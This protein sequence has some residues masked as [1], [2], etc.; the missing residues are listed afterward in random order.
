MATVLN[1]RRHRPVET[2]DESTPSEPPK[3]RRRRWVFLAILLMLLGVVFLPK[4]V[5]HTPALNW[6]VGSAAS[7]LRGSLSVESASLGWFSPV[8]LRDVR[9]EDSEGRPVLEVPKLSG[10]KSLLAILLNSSLLGEF[11]LDKPKLSISLRD[12]GSNVED[13]LADYLATDEESQRVGLRLK[14]IDGSV[15][16]V[17]TAAER[18]WRIDNL[19]LTLAT[20]SDPTR[21]VELEASAAIADPTSPGRL[22]VKLT[23]GAASAAKPS[24]DEK[25]DPPDSTGELAIETEQF[26]LDML[27][28][29]IARFSPETHLSGRV[30]SQ[31]HARWG[32]NATLA[33]DLMAENLLLATPALGSDRVD[34][35]HLDATCQLARQEGR[36]QIDEAT[37]RCDL[38]E[39]VVAAVLHDDETPDRGS[40]DWLS[41]QTYQVKGHLELVPLARMLPGTLRLRDGMQVTSGRLQLALASQPGP[42]GMLWEGTLESTDVTAVHRGQPIAW[43]NPIHLELAAHETPD[44]P[45]LDDLTCRSDFLQLQAGQTGGDLAASAQ[46][47]LKQL[48]DQLGRFADLGE[49]DFRGDGWGLLTWKRDAEQ[50][51]LDL[52]LQVHNFHLGLPEQEPWTEQSLLLLLAA[53]GQ[54]RPDE[55][56]RLLSA[57]LAV[58]AGGDRLEVELIAPVDRISTDG[59]WPVDLRLEGQLDR[60]PT[61]IRPWVADSMDDWPEPLRGWIEKKDYHASGNYKLQARGTGSTKQIVVEAAQLTIDRLHLSG[62]SLNV[63]QPRVVLDVAGQWDIEPGR[64]RLKPAGFSSNIVSLQ[65]DEL[66]LLLGG[67]GPMQMAGDVRFQGDLAPICQLLATPDKPLAWRMTGRLDGRAE[68]SQTGKTTQGRLDANI[69]N[70]T[71]VDS[72]NHRLVEPTVHLVAQGSYQ[73]ETNTVKLD[74]LQLASSSL[75][76][77]I[78]GQLNMAGETSTLN[79]AG[80]LNYDLERLAVLLRPYLGPDIRITGQGKRNISFDGPLDPAQA[81]AAA[82]LAWQSADVYGFPIGPGDLKATLANG[83]LRTEPI[84]LAISQGHVRLEPEV[85]FTDAGAQLVLPSGALVTQIQITPRMCGHALQYIAPVLAGVTEASGAFSVEL[86]GCRI[87]LADATQ[88]EL[89]GRLTVHSVQIGPGP[90]LRQFAMLL[91]RSGPARLR[92]ESVVRFH[93]IDGRVHHS[94]LELVFPDV[95]I[96]TAGSV[97]VDQT[98]SMIAEMP[99]PSKWIGDNPLGVAMRNQ[100]IRL[101]ITGTLSQPKIDRRQFDQIARQLLEGAARNVIQD[102][103]NRQLQHLFGPPP[104]VE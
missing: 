60:W 95:T 88:G 35:Q 24:N 81:R 28:P 20:S 77:G 47:D 10:K 57:S 76:A 49:L 15:S 80:E 19:Q 74:E 6:I 72:T 30:S 40:A 1:L 41:R 96:R 8:V 87:P 34:L 16:I 100:T 68:L 42:Q 61:R 23:L 103:L 99:I 3:K 86:D 104:G 84:D 90:L 62:P 70:L 98:L 29:L 36:I 26:P 69:T 78:Q 11:Q 39:L 63:E 51:Q 67:D 18:T 85:H 43:K 45:V 54:N 21:P 89:A 50:F 79:I 65:V 7:D 55:E 17:D 82:G 101:P 58:T 27:R 64:L 91:G 71:V 5:A 75:A 14:V 52:E 48:A 83:V 56:P 59:T 46:F 102:E 93:M 12:G 44:G 53:Q 32:V 4:I 73:Q 38:G 37:L 9:L 97:G 22:T 25:A 33:V 2:S 66:L 13:V 92:R 31:V 94:G